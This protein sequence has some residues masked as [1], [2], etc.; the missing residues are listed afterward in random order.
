[1]SEENNL[2]AEKNGGNLKYNLN[3]LISGLTGK[4]K[5][6]RAGILDPETQKKLKS[7]GYFS[8]T[9]SKKKKVFTEADDLKTLLPLQAKMHS[10]MAAHQSGDTQTAIR[11][12]KEIIKASPTYTLIYNHLAKIYK[13][14]RRT[15]LSVEILEQGLEKIPGEPFLLSKLGIFLVENGEFKRA[16]DVLENS[17]ILLKHDPECFNYLGVAYYR[18][19]NFNKALEN[20]NISLELDKNYAPVYNN[21]GSL[22]LSRFQRSKDRASYEKAILNFNK[23]IEIDKNL[24]SALNGRGAARYFSGDYSGAV[25]DWKRSISSKPD[26]IDPY[27]SIGIAYLLKLGDKESALKYFLLCREKFYHKLPDN[28]KA[29]L[30]RLIR[31]SQN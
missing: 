21:I 6:E 29:R 12:M 23:S 17:I 28:E 27:F 18:I 7:L 3:K 9:T 16:I 8:G 26:F 24:F 25:S 13:E 31:E 1:M 15:D 11:L 30:D 22:Y 4:E 14:L 5:L 2:I 19:G 10:A 20:Y